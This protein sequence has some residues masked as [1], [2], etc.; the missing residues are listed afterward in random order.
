MLDHI[1]GENAS[2]EMVR[3]A[4]KLTNNLLD[5]AL[6]TLKESARDAVPTDPLDRAYQ[7][8]LEGR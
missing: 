5:I 7:K 1:A 8:F 3:L 6:D 2:P 4:H